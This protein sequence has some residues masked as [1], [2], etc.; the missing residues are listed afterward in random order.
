MEEI[1]S[2]VL[3]DGT[4]IPDLTRQGAYFISE[5]ELAVSDFEGKTD[6][7]TI[8]AT[9]GEETQSDTYAYMVVTDLQKV[10]DEWAFIL[11]GLTEA[12]RKQIET[13]NQ[14][15]L[16]SDGLIEVAGMAAT[17]EASIDD[18]VTALME[19]A[20]IIEGGSE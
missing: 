18:V 4:V 13:D 9:I 5:K 8:N 2:L 6:L 17:N 3:S 19:L 11:D 12:D 1:Y 14:M 10:G 16:L 7:V 20:E 15:T